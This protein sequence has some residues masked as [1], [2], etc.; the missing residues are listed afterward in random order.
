MLNATLEKLAENDLTYF[1]L[2]HVVIV[3]TAVTTISLTPVT[4]KTDRHDITEIL[5]KVAFNIVLSVLL[6]FGHCAVCSSFF[7]SLCCLFFCLLVIVLSVLLTDSTMT[8]R[9]KDRQHNDQ[10][11]KDRQHNDQKTEGQTAQ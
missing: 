1:Y 11:K 5:L 10:K 9:Q 3:V 6:S 7:W 2:R 4:N 8:K